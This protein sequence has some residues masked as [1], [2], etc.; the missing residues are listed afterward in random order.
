MIVLSRQNLP[1]LDRAHYGSAAG[2]ARGAYVLK[3][4][5]P[6]DA[7]PQPRSPDCVL[8]GTGSEVQL[9]LEAAEKLAA[10]GVRARV[11][12]MPCWDLFA[13]QDAAY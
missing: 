9:C 13:E 7:G 2:V 6:Q 8:I 10:E 12:S 11:V 4:A 5:G 3:D 1:T